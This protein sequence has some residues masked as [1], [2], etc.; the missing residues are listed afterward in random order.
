MNPA[1]PMDAPNYTRA[2]LTN[3]ARGKTKWLRELELQRRCFVT[4]AMVEGSSWIGPIA[5]SRVGPRG[6]ERPSGDFARRFGFHSRRAHG[7]YVRSVQKSR[8]ARHGARVAI[9]GLQFWMRHPDGIMFT[10]TNRLVEGRPRTVQHP[11]FRGK[12]PCP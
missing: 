8:I 2:C 9:L 12:A 4:R 3:P 5:R 7:G 6:F 11:H 1:G 10:R